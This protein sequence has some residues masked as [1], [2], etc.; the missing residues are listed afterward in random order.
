MALESVFDGHYKSYLILKI[1][2]LIKTLSTQ[3][4]EINLIWIPAHK[5][6]IG[7]ERTDSLAKE[8]IRTGVDSQIGITTCEFKNLWKSK[9]YTEL[10]D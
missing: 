1:K 3:N 9:T 5:G 8:A 10:F 4:I 7:N 2:S 6:I